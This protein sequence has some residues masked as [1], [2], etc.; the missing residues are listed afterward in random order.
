[1]SIIIYLFE[2][3]P[4]I[5][6]IIVKLVISLHRKR[7]HFSPRTVVGLDLHWVYRDLHQFGA[8]AVHFVFEKYTLTSES[9]D[10]R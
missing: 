6:I 3:Q 4:P 10:T 7:S 5:I 9:S 2:F 8:V 1:M